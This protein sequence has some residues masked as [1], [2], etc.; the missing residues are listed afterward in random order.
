MFIH[1]HLRHGN[2]EVISWEMRNEK[3]MWIYR[4]SKCGVKSCLSIFD[5]VRS[6]VLK[7]INRTQQTNSN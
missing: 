2:N 1:L 4:N 3:C 5:S 7:F 6:K